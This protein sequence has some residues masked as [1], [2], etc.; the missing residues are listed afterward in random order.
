M[1]RSIL[2][3]GGT[4]G[5]G[6][7][8]ALNLARAFPSHKII[9]ASRTNTNNAAESINWTTKQSNVVYM[10]LDLSS[11][12]QVRAFA[13]EWSSQSHPP[14]EFLL[15]NAGVQL[16][17]PLQFTKDGYEKTF[18]INHM[19]QA[20]LFS[21]LTPYLADNARITITGSGTH[22]PAQPWPVPP[23]KYTTAEELAHPSSSAG[24]TD[25]AQ[26]YSNSKLA[27]LMWS[28][29]LE[30]RLAPLRDSGRKNW[31]VASFCPGMMPG[32]NLARDLNPVVRW[33]FKN[34]MP[35][36]IPVLR[37]VVGSKNIHTADVSG[38]AL[39]RIAT[40][41]EFRGVSGGYF[42]GGGEVKSS[43]ASYDEEKQEELW[44]WTVKSVAESPEEIARFRLRSLDA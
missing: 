31:T 21:L 11:L 14:I 1:S 2:I 28:Y 16:A 36:L 40:A 5:L 22:D 33:V 37:I 24:V 34:I 17:G 26:C 43:E 29:A 15:L 42:E 38:A 9:I 18:A 20:L 19:N 32:T 3:T 4:T 35:R 39:A 25:A 12:S 23:A 6:Y 41:E 13:S 30:R 27:S 8:A 7:N 44:T 10:H